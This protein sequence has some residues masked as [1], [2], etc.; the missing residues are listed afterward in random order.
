VSDVVDET[1]A[2][3]DAAAAAAAV[4]PE[5]RWPTAQQILR[6]SYLKTAVG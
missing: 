1:E 2:A 3:S 6:S 4:W 5:K